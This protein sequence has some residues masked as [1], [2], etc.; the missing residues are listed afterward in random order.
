MKVRLTSEEIKDGL[1]E[2]NLTI[3]GEGS[4]RASIAFDNTMSISFLS[5]NPTQAMFKDITELY[6]FRYVQME[7]TKELVKYT[8]IINKNKGTRLFSESEVKSLLGFPDG[9]NIL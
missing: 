2:F 8:E 5:L 7:L 1:I 4:Y 6:R 9:T 3:V